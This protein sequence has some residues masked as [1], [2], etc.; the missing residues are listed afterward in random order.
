MKKFVSGLLIGILITLSIT[1]FA[2]VEL[3][4]M[5]NPYDVLINGDKADVTGYNIS[6]STYLKLTDFKQAGLDVNFNKDKKQIEI[7]TPSSTSE[8]TEPAPT[9]TT[10]NGGEAKVDKSITETKKPNPLEGI[11]T[12]APVITGNGDEEDRAREENRK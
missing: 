8:S 3:K 11:D 12:T 10:T 9:S 1:T 7:A 6:G 4:I 2:A 5:P